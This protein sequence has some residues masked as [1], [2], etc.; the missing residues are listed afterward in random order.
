LLS[1]H[2]KAKKETM[3]INYRVAVALVAGITI[4][5]AVIQGLH[6]QTKPPIY[7]VTEITVTDPDAY[8][9]EFVLKA[10]ANI[11]AAGVREVA[12]GGLGGPGPQVTA[13][14]GEPPKRVVIQVFDSLEKM[15]AFREGADYT[16]AKKIGDKYATYRSYAVDGVAH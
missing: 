16:A 10:Q 11:K 13:V 6:A 5:G 4:G 9:K 2:Q 1:G 14:E 15:K 8:R 12:L 3:K 7:L